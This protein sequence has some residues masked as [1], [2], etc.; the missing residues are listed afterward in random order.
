MIRL[1]H[2]TEDETKIKTNDFV[3]YICMECSME[4]GERL[5]S[6]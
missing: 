5:H 3:Q 1:P 4:M 2:E 6:T